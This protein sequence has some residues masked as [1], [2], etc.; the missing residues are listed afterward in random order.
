MP[1]THQHTPNERYKIVGVRNS[2]EENWHAHH[3]EY[4]LK[5]SRTK[6]NQI[7]SILTKRW[8]REM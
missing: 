2:T 1:S 3:H 5:H 7:G 4:W 6:L 8:M